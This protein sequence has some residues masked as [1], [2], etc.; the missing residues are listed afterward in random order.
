MGTHW[1]KKKSQDSFEHPR[2]TSSLPREKS[3]L[4]LLSSLKSHSFSFSFTGAKAPP[5]NLFILYNQLRKEEFK[6]K[7]EKRGQ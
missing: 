5:P 1:K 6:I 7:P 2:V 3:S 4:C